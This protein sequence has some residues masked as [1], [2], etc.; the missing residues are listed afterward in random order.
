MY[1]FFSILYVHLSNGLFVP[2]KRKK[3]YAL[4]INQKMSS[5]APGKVN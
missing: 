3:I 1:L 5:S 2:V 4:H